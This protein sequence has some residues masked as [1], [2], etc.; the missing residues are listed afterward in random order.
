MEEKFD[1]IIIGS[2]LG[3]LE[4]AMILAKE[5]YKVC[6]LEKNQQF[7]GCLQTFKSDGVIFDTGVHYVGGLDEGQS[8]HQYFSYFDILDKLHYKRMDDG[9]FEH[10]SY[11]NDEKIYKYGM[12]L[13]NFVDTLVKDFPEEKE[14]LELD[15]KT[16]FE[17]GRNFPFYHLTDEEY[18]ETLSF[19]FVDVSIYEYLEKN[20]KSEKL[21]SVLAGTN[22]L[23]AGDPKTATLYE[24]ALIIYAYVE[25]SYRFIDGAGQIAQALVR[26]L[27]KLG[28]KVKRYQKVQTIK[29]ED[30]KAQYVELDN[31]KR[32]YA[33]KFISNVHPQTTLKMLDGAVIR[34]YYTNRLNSIPNSSSAF[35]L[36]I[37]LEE[38]TVPYQ[39]FN[40]YHFKHNNVWDGEDYTQENWPLNYM[41]FT[42]ISSKSEKYADS[43]IAIAYMN[44]DEVAKWANTENVV[45]FIQERGEDY[46]AFKQHKSEV[47][48]NEVYKRFP[49]IKGKVVSHCA[50][51]PLTY[52]DYL[53]SPDGS[54]Y[55]Y[56]KDFNNPLKAYLSPQSKVSNLFFTG[57]NVNMHGVL[58]V[59]VSAFMTCGE[60]LGKKYLY[61]KVKIKSPKII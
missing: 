5:G 8:L 15:G 59:T 61:D 16:L 9:G 46:E 29:V 37:V 25:S 60:I 23:Y 42:P 41:A 13:Q 26:N 48:L 51:T 45:G 10:I 53:Y 44:F 12:G 43:M 49:E 52:R 24:H 2:G 58:G 21:K 30:N 22:L 14:A 35:A 17:V 32:Y 34:K 18:T 27:R 19:D 47:L 54:I 38:D 36:H 4:S 3:G 40:V 11:D 1:V 55:G 39:N 20:F 50:S 57:Q 6:V 33:D 28:C 7:G 31:G 56:A